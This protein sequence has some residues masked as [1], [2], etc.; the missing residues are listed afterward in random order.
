M[1][2]MTLT[3]HFRQA[4]EKAN[5]LAPPPKPRQS[6]FYMPAMPSMGLIRALDMG[7]W[8]CRRRLLFRR[9]MLPLLAYGD[10]VACETGYSRDD[11][12][13]ASQLPLKVD[14]IHA[15]EDLA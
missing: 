8:R 5:G 3:Q 4:W 11:I 9:H 13:W 7:W 1:N 10:Q 6:G 12:L 14:A 15:L 2:E